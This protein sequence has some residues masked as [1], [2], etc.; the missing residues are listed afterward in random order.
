MSSLFWKFLK[1]P[2]QVG[3][4]CASSPALCREITSAI[5]VESADLIAELG[6][7]TGVITEEIC[8][9]LKPGAKLAAVELDE[10]L[11]NG[12]ERRFKNVTVFRGC[13][14]QLDTMLNSRAL[15]KADVV[16]SGLPFAI[17]PEELQEKILR[18]IVRSLVPGGTFATFAYLQGVILPAGVRFRRKLENTFPEVTTSQIVWN[19]MPP[20]FVYRCR[21]LGE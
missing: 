3:A 12:I 14:S 7:G 4:C 1:N 6:P 16:I 11:A 2:R 15:P 13:A 8:S 17:F 21:K 10:A 5:G 19:N 9:K 18:G 20:A